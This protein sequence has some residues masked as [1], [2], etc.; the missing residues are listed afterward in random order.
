MLT[1]LRSCRRRAAARAWCSGT[2]PGRLVRRRSGRARATSARRRPVSV[3]AVEGR[4]SGRRRCVRRTARWRCRAEHGDGAAFCDRRRRSGTGRRPASGPGPAASDG[5]VPTT[6]VVQLVVPAVSDRDGGRRRRRPRR[7]PARRSVDASASASLHGQRGRRPK[8]P[9]TP[10][11]L[12]ACCPGETIS[13]LV[14]SALIWARTC[15]CA[16]SPEPDGEDHRGDADQDAEHGQ[17]RAQPVRAD[18]LAS[19]S[20]AC[21]ASSC[22]PPPRHELG[23]SSW[24]WP[25]RSRTMRSARS[26]TSARG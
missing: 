2:T 9:R 21:P 10:P 25:S 1:E 7:C 16:P 8:P 11:V 17:R 26:A 12:G 18:G 15:A 22:R 20:E 3:D 6:L 19:R 4:R 5:V 23:V 24:T 13:R 14:P